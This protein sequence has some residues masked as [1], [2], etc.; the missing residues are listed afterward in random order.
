[1]YR[2]A[3][4]FIA[5]FRVYLPDC[6]LVVNLNGQKADVKAIPVPPRQLESGVQVHGYNIEISHDIFGFA[7]RTKF[8]LILH[9]TVNISDADWKR[10]VA[11]RDKEILHKGIL[12]TNRLLEVYRS[13]DRNRL[14]EESFHVIPLVRADLSNIRIVVVD[15]DLNELPNFVITWPTFQRV[16]M[17]EAIQRDANIE[18]EIRRV[19]Q[20]GEQIPVE[21][22]LINSAK[23]NLW[24][25]IYQLVPIEANT[26][27]E[28][29]VPMAIAQIDPSV[30]TEELP[31]LYSKLLKL[32]DVL[33]DKLT[34]LNHAGV[35]WF[36]SPANGWQTLVESN[37]SQWHSDCY[38][39][40]HKVIHQG[41]NEVSEQEAKSA[42]ESMI[43]A[44]QY[45]QTEID[46]I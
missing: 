7:G 6:F 21:R 46:R 42:V 20:S 30:N 19:L 33:N 11:N 15:N 4:D 43:A 38:I 17:G 16:G 9:E 29:F 25:G 34:S 18:E 45:I 14:G 41:Y 3:I 8:C 27:F 23:N 2:I 32:Q 39:I 22:E 31:N 40:R 26:A 24:R 36:S 5:P 28:S 37:I 35:S 12:F 1:M 13:I 10:S 44:K